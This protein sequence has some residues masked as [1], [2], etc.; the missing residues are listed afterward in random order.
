MSED[1]IIQAWFKK[2]TAPTQSVDCDVFNISELTSFDDSLNSQSLSFN[3]APYSPENAVTDE[4]ATEGTKTFGKVVYTVVVSDQNGQELH[5]E[6]FSTASGTL[7]Y[8]VT[9]NL[10]ITGFYSY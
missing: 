10:K 6:N 3:F 1:M 5:R 4:N 7:N 2:G 9:S 8:A